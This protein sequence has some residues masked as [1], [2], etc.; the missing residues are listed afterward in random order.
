[1]GLPLLLRTVLP[2]GLM[3]LMMSAYF[4]AIMSTADS[5]LMAS[6]GNVLTDILD[7]IFHFRHDSKK[8]LRISQILTFVIGGSALLLALK[9]QNVLELMLYSYA[10]MV[11]GLFI[12][13]LGAL[14]WKKSSPVAAFWSMLIGGGT[15]LYLTIAQ[16]KL[17]FALDPNI[18]GISASLILFV[19]L[20]YLFPR[21][22]YGGHQQAFHQK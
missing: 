3:G 4:S 22:R 21:T 6:S 19:V 17:P 5:C 10:F 2:V 16:F 15:T 1:M 20:T 13:I 8:V 12:P 11:S 18:F 14:F 7:K 9:M